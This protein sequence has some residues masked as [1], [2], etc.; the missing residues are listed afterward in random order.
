MCNLVVCALGSAVNALL[1]YA[2]ID[3]AGLG[4]KYGIDVNFTTLSLLFAF[5]ITVLKSL[6]YAGCHNGVRSSFHIP[7]NNLSHRLP[8][9]TRSCWKGC[10]NLD[11]V[12]LC[13]LALIPGDG[14]FAGFTRR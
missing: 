10:G 12:S 5:T 2:L 4:L 14:H 13:R 9:T 7:S 1:H 11:C 3:Q 6:A 8:K